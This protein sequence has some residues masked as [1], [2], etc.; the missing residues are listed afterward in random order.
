MSVSEPKVKTTPHKLLHL[1]SHLFVLEATLN[2]TQGRTGTFLA[3]DVLRVCCNW[4]SGLAFL[5]GFVDELRNYIGIPRKISH[6]PRNTAGNMHDN[7]QY[8][9]NLRVL[10]DQLPHFSSGLHM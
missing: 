2:F 3:I 6:I 1:L 7:W 4:C 8:W 9:N 10:P 5:R